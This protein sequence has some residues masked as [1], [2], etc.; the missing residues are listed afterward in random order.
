MINHK[1]QRTALFPGNIKNTDDLLIYSSQIKMLVSNKRLLKKWANYVDIEHFDIDQVVSIDN[2]APLCLTGSLAYPDIVRYVLNDSSTYHI[3]RR[4]ISAKSLYEIDL[5]AE[6]VIYWCIDKLLSNNIDCVIHHNTPHEVVSYVFS[7]VAEFLKIP[8]YTIRQS[9]IPWRAYIQKGAFNSGRLERNEKAV[10]QADYEEVSAFL[11]KKIQDYNQA[12]PEYEKE[13]LIRLKGNFWSW[14]KEIRTALNLKNNPIKSFYSL[15]LKYRLFRFFQSKVSDKASW[16]SKFVTFYLHYQP[17]RTTLPEG[18]IY[19]QQ[20]IAIRALRLLLP[21][22]ISIVVREHPST[23]R[24]SFSLTTRSELFYSRITS[25]ENVH[26]CP[27]QLDSF[28]VLD[29]S[30]FVLTTTGTVAIEASVRGKCTVFFGNACYQGMPGTYSIYEFLENRAIL[31][32]LI[33]KPLS[34]DF[35]EV[36]SFFE[37]H[38]YD[39]FNAFIEPLDVM[40]RGQSWMAA[41]EAL[42]YLLELKG[43]YH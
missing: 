23:F 22:D 43:S 18:G 24:N 25:L 16:G 27:L 13:R 39:S 11:T 10:K 34:P 35:N 32:T 4:K 33:D 19:N 21:K 8:I 17:E 12:I 42:K 20:L 7:K 5:Y 40:G 31:E 26:L 30:L 36:I 3:L 41:N 29:S 28:E 1:F 14:E 15:Y 37:N 38:Y 2:I 6:R 9:P